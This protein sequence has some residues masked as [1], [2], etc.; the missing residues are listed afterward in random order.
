MM[1]S[2]KEQAAAMYAE[3]IAGHDKNPIIE[4]QELR[5][6]IERGAVIDAINRAIFLRDYYYYT[7]DYVEQLAIVHRLVNNY[8]EVWQRRQ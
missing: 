6:D 5:E 1:R 4:D 2:L 3:F 8:G 7:P